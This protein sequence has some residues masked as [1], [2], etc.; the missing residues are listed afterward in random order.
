M[1]G[2]PAEPQTSGGRGIVLRRGHM[3]FMSNLILAKW[4]SF[5]VSVR[6]TSVT[7]AVRDSVNIVNTILA[8]NAAAYEPSTTPAFTDVQFAALF[9][10]DNHRTEASAA[11]VIANL[12]PASFDW[13]PTGNAATGCNTVAIP[14][15]YNVTNFFGGTLALPAYC[16]AVDPAG[17][18][19]YE[20]W[21][22][23]AV[24]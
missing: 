14:G 5:A 21:T 18:K 15:T 16:G 6:D 17:P 20:G 11:G 9:A 7:L 10:T 22:T 19:W 2:N 12:T 23:Y 24:N 8:E 1:V 4:K 3:G 13:T